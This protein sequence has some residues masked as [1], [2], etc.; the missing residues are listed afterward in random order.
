[1]SIN[2]QKKVIR[3]EILEELEKLEKETEEISKEQQYRY[4]FG[5]RSK[6]NILLKINRSATK[7]KGL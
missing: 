7:G 6:R 4:V 1:M 2:E 3:E 5:R